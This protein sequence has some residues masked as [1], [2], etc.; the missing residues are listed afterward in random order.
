VAVI[1]KAVVRFYCFRKGNMKFVQKK[2]KEGSRYLL[3]NLLKDDLVCI[4]NIGKMV[5][6][7]IVYLR[8]EGSQTVNGYTIYFIFCRANKP[9]A[10]KKKQGH[11]LER[12]EILALLIN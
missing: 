1:R 7:A 6:K 5:E 12:A 8:W 10:K 2:R 4:Y 11:F 3:G 9:S